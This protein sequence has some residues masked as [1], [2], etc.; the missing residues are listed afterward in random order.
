MRVSVETDVTKSPDEVFAFLA[1]HANHAKIFREN[2]SCE[3]ISPGPMAAGT[4]VKNVARV[5]GKTMVEEFSVTEFRPPC[6]LAKSSLEGSTFETTDR[7]DLE[8][9]EKGTRVRVTVT[10]TPAN[11]GQ[12]LMMVVLT[13]IMRRSLRRALSELK[14]ILE[15]GDR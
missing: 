4:R 14:R 3:Q 15:T 8:A 7:F 5:M 1:H 9:I 12:R 10:G 13:P 2:V 6:V 11:V